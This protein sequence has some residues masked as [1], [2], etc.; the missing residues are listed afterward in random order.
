M[1]ITA[2]ALPPAVPAEF[3]GRART[4]LTRLEA[5]EPS[6]VAALGTITLPLRDKHRRRAKLAAGDTTAA[7]RAWLEQLPPF[8]RIATETRSSRV[9]LYVRE[10]RLFARTENF[11][12]WSGTVEPTIAILL[13]GVDQRRKR[14]EASKA[15][16]ALIGLHAM[17]RRYQRG[18]DTT[19]E[20]IFAEFRTI[21]KVANEIT[22]AGT[23]FR[24]PV[25]NGV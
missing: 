22:D 3:R 13:I 6:Y 14:L 24:I 12:T 8:G 20:T 9:N 18:F 1:S 10:L 17:A 16:L 19:D 15:T 4:F 11:D 7:E 23:D 21:A 5:V 2:S 25:S